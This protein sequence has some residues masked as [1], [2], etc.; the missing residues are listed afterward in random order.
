M[1][2]DAL[3]LMSVCFLLMAFFFIFHPVLATASMV[4]TLDDPRLGGDGEPQGLLL[5]V[6]NKDLLEARIVKIVDGDTLD[7]RFLNSGEKF[8]VRLIGVD[9]PETKHPMR[10][11]EPFGEEATNFV[12]SLL[13]EN[14]V[15]LLEFDA[16]RQDR[17]GR[18][19]AYVWLEEPEDRSA[20][21]GTKM[22]NGLLLSQGLARIATFPPNVKY[23]NSL[24]LLQQKARTEKNGFWALDRPGSRHKLQPIGHDIEGGHIQ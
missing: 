12:T 5:R 20:E 16:Q 17:Y 22:L 8:R 13:G 15:V 24:L 2:K 7:V 14:S 11:K 19:L 4:W 3:F 23:S 1:K 18:L 21:I 9:A 10:T 6:K